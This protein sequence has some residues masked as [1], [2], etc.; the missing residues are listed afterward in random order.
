MSTN[1]QETNRQTG[2]RPGPRGDSTRGGSPKNTNE[3]MPVF[4][5]SKQID[6]TV[7]ASKDAETLNLAKLVDDTVAL[8]RQ[9]E[10]LLFGKYEKRIPVKHYADSE[11]T[12]ESVASTKPIETKR[13]RNQ[14]QELKEVLIEGEVDSFS[15]LPAKSMIA[16]M[17][18]KEMKMLDTVQNLKLK[19]EFSLPP[20]DVN[21]VKSEGDELRM[22]NIRNRKPS[23]TDDLQNDEENGKREE[24][25][26]IDD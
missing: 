11:P 3:K 22:Y 21:K 9:F 20:T 23:S 13:L 12:L 2:N 24:G 8:A 6:R 10:I 7:H 16:D 18:T 5:I 19:N 25:G 17:L 4:W 1:K 26:M 14:I 15:W